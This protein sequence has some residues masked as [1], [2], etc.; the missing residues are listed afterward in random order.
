MD[1]LIKVIV[2]RSKHCHFK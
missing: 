1:E 2:V